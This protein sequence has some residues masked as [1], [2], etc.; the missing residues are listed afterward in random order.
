MARD[1][2]DF[3]E[4]KS[5]WRATASALA[6][7]AM[8]ASIA[9]QAAQAQDVVVGSSDNG[10]ADDEQ[11]Q[12]DLTALSLT[13][14]SSPTSV[15]PFSFQLDPEI[16][17]G[18]NTSDVSILFDTDNDGN[19]NYSYVVTLG[20]DPAG[21]TQFAVLGISLQLGRNDSSPIK[22]AGNTT[23]FPIGT[24]TA[25]V[26]TA[27]NPFDGGTDTLVT[28]DLD[29]QAIADSD[30]ALSLADVRF[31]NLTTIPS[32]SATSNP[33]DVLLATEQAYTADD[34]GTTDVDTT[35]AIDT[36]VNDSLKIDWSTAVITSPPSHGTATINADGTIN[37]VPNG[38]YTGIDTLTY[39]ATATDCSTYTANVAITITGIA[40]VDDSASVVGTVA[41]LPAVLN[42]F[43][44]DSIDG[45]TASASNTTLAIAPASSLPSAL[46]FSTSTGAVGVA[47]GAAPG[48]YTFD[49]Q[50]CRSGSPTDCKIAT[51]TVEIASV[52]LVTSKE[53]TS[54]D[55]T[56]KAGD[57]VTFTITVTNNGAAD[58]TGVS[59]TDLLPA[60][61]TATSNN[62]NVSAGTYDA[63]T[64][65]WSIGTL[66]NGASA[67]LTI[68]GTVDAG[69]GGQTITNTIANPATA[70]ETDTTTT[71]DDLTESVT[72]TPQV[73]LSIAKTNGSTEV[74]SGSTTTYTLTVS[75]IGGDSIT[76]AVVSDTPGAG[77]TCDAASSVTITGDGVPSG[78][79]TI[80]DLAG[81][82]IALGTLV[83]GQ[84]TSLT[85]SCQ[86]N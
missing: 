50:L 86:V 54:G 38:N 77:L 75:H 67:T 45:V 52:D 48:T 18:N 78:S 19:A 85:Y 2:A 79:F 1:I 72:V 11:E 15:I 80:A 5:S 56:P 65:L 36:Q 10:G 20:P 69:Q 58:A 4:R 76:G 30:P 46:T 68:E 27:T 51:V 8:L 7:A 22:V 41:G 32:S 71:G 25:T 57:T 60:G 55:P 21:G 39:S 34:I 53:L 23:S 83:A 31:L 66:A 84:S 3:G 37:Y 44:N 42:V 40:A 82:G 16:N 74:F 26:G 47:P 24:T 33:K 13:C 6:A 43:D 61:L 17:S 14:P 59:L 62:G 73:D 12:S 29:F 35:I 9:S 81:A 64:G 70:N 49:Y 63:G 28:L